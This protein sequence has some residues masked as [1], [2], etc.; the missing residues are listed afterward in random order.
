[1]RFKGALSVA[2]VF[3]TLG[4]AAAAASGANAGT[5][6]TLPLTGF[7]QIVA[8]S[9]HG[10]LFL[11]QGSSGGAIVVTNLSGQEVV[12]IYARAFGGTSQTLLRSGRVDSRG[13]LSV[14]YAPA[15]STAFSAVFRG[16]ARYA[17]KTVIR[18]VYVRAAVSASIGGYYTSTHIGGTLYR[19]FHHTAALRLA[20]AVAPNKRGECVT[21]QVPAAPST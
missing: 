10:R 5:V 13:E 17:P 12:S 18:D 14:S 16:D 9:A 6:A 21:V 19:V 20:V 8:D 15:H 7:Y 3:G 1:M 11:G 4:M 2:T